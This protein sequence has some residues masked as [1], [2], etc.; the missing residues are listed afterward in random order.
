MS[1]DAREPTR[2]RRASAGDG[3]FIVGLVGRVGSGKSTVAKALAANGAAVIDADLLGHEVTDRD[4]EV[5][6]ALAREYGPDVYGPDGQLDR[7]RVAARV[8]ADPEARARF[9]G[10]VHPR[11]VARIQSRLDEL[12]ARGFRGVVILDA[13]LLLEWGLERSCDAVI[14]VS[15]PMDEQVRR[16]AALRG[17]TE[18]QARQRLRAQRSERSFDAAADV[19][20]HNT[21]SIEELT[22]AARATLARLRAQAPQGKG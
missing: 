21:G 1:T 8:F 11:L 20:L 22:A 18:E 9:D 6:A 7:P 12:R 17:W 2:P 4:P 14:G 5:R 3:L 16:L 13:A 15:A 19:T 10:L